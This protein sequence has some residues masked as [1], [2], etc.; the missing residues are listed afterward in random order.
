MPRFPECGTDITR[1]QALNMLLTSIAMEELGFSHIINAEGEK[2][3]YVLR[4]LKETDIPCDQTQKL[5]EVNMSIT[6]LLEMVMQN[7]IILKSKMERV[8][9]E[10]VPEPPPVC[11]GNTGIDE[12]IG[13]MLFVNACP[14]HIWQKDCVFPWKPV[15][16]TGGNISWNKQEPAV[17]HLCQNHKYRISFTFYIQA[18]PHICSNA[19]TV[20]LQKLVRDCFHGALSFNYCIRENSKYLHCMS[21]NTILQYEGAKTASAIAFLLESPENMTVKQAALNIAELKQLDPVHD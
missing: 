16:P 5:L 10:H 11:P 1:E 8:L 20:C 15:S 12:M 14:D 3:Q 21:G 7:Q 18:C 6:K 17:I 13:S 4:Y 9:S 2:L 19:V